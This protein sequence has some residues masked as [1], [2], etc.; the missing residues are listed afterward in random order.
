MITLK[1]HFRTLRKKKKRYYIFYWRPG[2][3]SRALSYIYTITDLL[4]ASWWGN[5]K[6]QDALQQPGDDYAVVIKSTDDFKS[7]YLQRQWNVSNNLP[8]LFQF[9]YLYVQIWRLF[10]DLI[11]RYWLGMTHGVMWISSDTLK[12]FIKNSLILLKHLSPW[13]IF[14]ANHCDI[15]SSIYNEQSAIVSSVT[16]LNK[17]IT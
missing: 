10:E 13:L 2:A 3:T 11:N 4:A 17:I 9:D 14:K 16:Q 8:E 7:E 6:S 15:I 1:C 5:I 12:V